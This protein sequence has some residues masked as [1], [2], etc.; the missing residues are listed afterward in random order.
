MIYILLLSSI[1]VSILFYIYSK[2]ALSQSVEKS[3]VNTLAFLFLS[4][5]IAYL[6]NKI[7]NI[8]DA[9]VPI[10]E[11]PKSNDDDNTSSYVGLTQNLKS[12]FE[13]FDKL[14]KFS[15]STN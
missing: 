3:I 11:A 15:I 12:Q 6:V 9:S 13:E 14:T 4:M 5:G 7:W 10:P 8:K 1:V 2:Y